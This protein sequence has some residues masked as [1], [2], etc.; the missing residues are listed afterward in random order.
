MPASEEVAACAAGRTGA[1]DASMP[2]AVP[3]G[4]RAVGVARGLES[5]LGAEGG[6]TVL[7]TRWEKFKPATLVR[8]L[9]QGCQEDRGD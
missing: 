2:G 4:G 6:A 7:P 1:P 8:S 5:S 9:T 3:V